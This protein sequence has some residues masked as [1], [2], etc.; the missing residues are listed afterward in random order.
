MRSMNPLVR[1]V[2]LV[3][4]ALVSS[5]GTAPCQALGALEALQ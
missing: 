4:L 2:L 1:N 5:G 3:I